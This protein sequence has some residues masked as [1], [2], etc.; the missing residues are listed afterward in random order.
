MTE[1]PEG[2]EELRNFPQGRAIKHLRAFLGK[3]QDEIAALAGVSKAAVSLWEREKVSSIQYDT[4]KRLV[5]AVGLSMDDFNQFTETNDERYIA[6]ARWPEDHMPSAAER[7]VRHGTRWNGPGYDPGRD[8]L[9]WGPLA[10]RAPACLADVIRERER[11]DRVATRLYTAPEDQAVES[12]QKLMQLL[13]SAILEA[14]SISA[15]FDLVFARS[16]TSLVIALAGANNSD[17][18]ETG[19][20]DG[21][22]HPVRVDAPKRVFLTAAAY[23]ATR[24]SGTAKLSGPALGGPPLHGPVF[25]RSDDALLTVLDV[26]T[27]TPASLNGFFYHLAAETVRVGRHLLGDA[28][29]QLVV[30]APAIDEFAAGRSLGASRKGDIGRKLDELQ[31][32]TDAALADGLELVKLLGWSVAVVPD[33]IAL[34]HHVAEFVGVPP[35]PSLPD[36][37][38]RFGAVDDDGALTWGKW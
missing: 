8:P 14:T 27:R 9:E 24:D 30:I 23:A 10:R 1:E 38:A 34:T 16:Y 29:V 12:T 22:Y 6:S 31:R 35:P 25:L 2:T 26:S 7:I 13:R 37:D 19:R 28:P 5:E 20:I 32:E 3:N 17:H 18:I 15:R 4:I 33:V 21:H 11:A 36:P